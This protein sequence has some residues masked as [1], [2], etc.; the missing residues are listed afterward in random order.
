MATREAC[1]LL[2]RLLTQRRRDDLLSTAMTTSGFFVTVLADFLSN[3]VS[4]LDQLIFTL[5]FVCIRQER[6]SVER[7]GVPEHRASEVRDLVRVEQVVPARQPLIRR[8]IEHQHVVSRAST[9]PTS[10]DFAALSLFHRDFVTVS[11][12][13]AE[14]AMLFVGE[15]G[16]WRLL[17]QS[18]CRG[19]AARTTSYDND[20]EN[21]PIGHVYWL[22]S[23]S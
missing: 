7:V 13:P 14:S 10:L 4:D 8:R 23:C 1:L 15:E 16:G 9:G 17:S 5:V 2:V 22:S 6:I 11:T 20:V 18:R 12:Y 21:L 19:E 3:T